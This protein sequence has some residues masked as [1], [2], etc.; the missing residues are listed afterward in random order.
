VF[1]TMV[2]CD[3]WNTLYID[4]RLTGA[5]VVKQGTG[6]G[7]QDVA[8]ASIYRVFKTVLSLLRKRPL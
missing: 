5:V 7:L 1:W 6:Q 8:L 2:M 4:G 3:F